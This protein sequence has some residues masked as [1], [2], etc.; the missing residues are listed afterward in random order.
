MYF[1]Y[2]MYDFWGYMSHA[3]SKS[4]IKTIFEP[5]ESTKHENDYQYKI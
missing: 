5:L 4:L 3:T 1:N 2:S